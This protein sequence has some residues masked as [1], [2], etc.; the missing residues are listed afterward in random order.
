MI[1]IHRRWWVVVD[2]AELHS[3]TFTA[4]V[5]AGWRGAVVVVEGKDGRSLTSLK[6]MHNVCVCVCGGG[7][8][9]WRV[10]EVIHSLGT[11]FLRYVLVNPPWAMTEIQGP[12]TWKC[13]DAKNAHVFLR[14]GRPSTRILKKHFFWNQVSGRRNPTTQPSRFHVDGESAYFPK[15]WRH[16]PT[17]RPLASDLWTPR[18]LITTTTTMETTCLC[19]CRRR[20][21]PFLQ[22]TCLVVECELQQ[23]FS[24]I[25]GPH[26]RFWF[27][28][29]SRFHLLLVVFS[30][31]VYCLFVYSA[32]A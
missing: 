11:A 31:S 17:P 27:P 16:R 28:C 30:F 8:W 20:I 25:T 26:K 15:R 6:L 3:C 13:S 10:M 21:Q 14:F 2:D 9:I 18:R 29:T 22:F 12:S 32:Q 5:K 23:Q 4:G 24:I 7:G 1:V 19:S